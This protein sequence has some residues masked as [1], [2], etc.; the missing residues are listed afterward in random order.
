[1]RVCIDYSI[2]LKNPMPA[3]LLDVLRNDYGIRCRVKEI[4]S[5]KIDL[6]EHLMEDALDIISSFKSETVILERYETGRYTLT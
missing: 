1:M 3:E 4:P 5:Q 2:V 6:P